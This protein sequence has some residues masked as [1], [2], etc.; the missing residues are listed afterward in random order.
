[1]PQDGRSRRRRRSGE[2]RV[3]V[4]DGR[5]LPSGP[6]MARAIAQDRAGQ[7]DRKPSPV[8][9][10]FEVAMQRGI[11]PGQAVLSVSCFEPGDEAFRQLVRRT[12]SIRWVAVIDAAPQRPA[13]ARRAVPACIL[14][15][16]GLASI[17]RP[18]RLRAPSEQ[19]L[20]LGGRD[21]ERVPVLLETGSSGRSAG[22][23][24]RAE[25]PRRRA[26]RTEREARRR[27]CGSSADRGQIA[28][29]MHVSVILGSLR[30]TIRSHPRSRDG[31]GPSRGRPHARGPNP[32]ASRH[33]RARTA[34][35]GTG[36]DGRD[37]PCSRPSCPR[38]YNRRPASRSGC[39]GRP[40]AARTSRQNCSTV[41][42]RNSASRSISSG[43]TQ[44]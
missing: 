39:S 14:P 23:P 7:V 36:R 20:D 21:E 2:S 15:G 34:R 28:V 38:R 17:E 41:S 16:A 18:L 40:P 30:W 19:E 42:P 5:R 11:V 12:R 35:S 3:K 13:L 4:D 24:A 32:L 31:L 25:P 37:R 43:E 22:R 6:P 29:A 27:P 33:F 26:R 10:R 44:T 1:M 8:T 9:F